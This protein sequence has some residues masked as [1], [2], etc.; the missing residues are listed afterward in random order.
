MVRRGATPRLFCGLIIAGVLLALPSAWGQFTW[1]V[2]EPFG[3]YTNTT[4]L[5]GGDSTNFWNFGNGGG[6]GVNSYVVTPAAALTFPALVTET[7]AVPAG[8]QSAYVNDT[9]A[10]AGA[11]F[12]A[13]TGTIYASFLLNYIDNG[14]ASTTPGDRIIF[15]LVTNGVA[16]LGS[17]YTHVW[18]AVTLT[19]DYGIKIDKDINSGGTYSAEFP[20]ATNVTHLIVLSYQTNKTA[21]SPD[22]VNLWVDPAPF[23]NNASIPP[24]VLS[25]TNG[26]NIGIFGAMMLDDRASPV[27]YANNFMIDEIRLN[28]TWAGV[29]PL[30]TAAPGPMF[31]VKGG[32]TSCGGPEDVYLSGS[33][34]TNNYL[35]YTNGAY[36]GVTLAGTGSGTLD[37]GQQTAIGYYSVLASNLNTAS[38]GWM[39][40]SATIA[41]VQPPVIV[42]EPVPAVAATNNRAAFTTVITGVKLAYQWYRDGTPLT[43]DSHLSG[44]TTNALVISPVGTADIGNYYCFVVDECGNTAYT[45]TNSLSL[46]SPN[47]ITWNGDAYDIDVWDISTTAEFIDTNDTSVVF[48][49]GDNVTFDDTYTYNTPV[50]LNGTLTPS[51]ITVNAARNYTW[52]GSGFITGTASLVKSNTGALL[53]NNNSAASYLNSYTGGT[54]IYGGSLNISNGWSLLGTGPVTLAGGTLESYQKGNGTSTGLPNPVYVTAS[55]TWQVDRTG[56]QCGALLGAL[57]G[58]SGTTLTIFNDVAAN[59]TNR[60]YL[61]ASFTN[62]SAIVLSSDFSST[63]VEL[64]PVNPSTNTEIFNGA[65]SGNGQFTKVGAGAVYLNAANTYLGPTTNSAGLLAGTGSVSSA[66]FVASNATVGAG[67]PTAIGTFT[68]NNTLTLAGNVFIRVTKSPTKAN[69]LISV[70]GAITNISTGTITVTNLGAVALA[71][72]DTFQIFSGSVSNGAAL[73]VTGGGVTWSNNLALNGSIQALQVLPVLITIPPA[74]TNFTLSGANAII[75]GTNGQAGSTCYLLMTTNL[76]NPRSQWKT[77]ATN[78]L[79]GNAYLFTETN[80]ISAGSA[81]Q[82]FML[83]STNYNP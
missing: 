17:S 47:N 76:G 48:N 56:S 66:M 18:T 42:T 1:P 72:G 20:L 36:A 11:T 34:A 78:V 35:L 68:V 54:I 14:S 10:D 26:A 55:S 24:P 13:H 79:G 58:S 5:A 7:N 23:G 74:I 30:A 29:T 12:T 44:A 71:A 2:Y 8:V 75:S 83:S 59:L 51:S 6:A 62:N 61:G 32:G 22:T 21:G 46:D 39:S 69:D 33:V 60:V 25:T 16:T 28:D 41:I 40:N 45:T 57:M 67:S 81:H 27:Y 38:V 31:T 15:Q 50:T 37:F 52:A 65:I 43:N 49:P 82:F 63:V 4:D 80:A 70:T 9:S 64:S 73:T 77:V 3:E 19:A 53:I